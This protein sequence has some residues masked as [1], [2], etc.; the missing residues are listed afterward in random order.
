VKGRRAGGAV[1][2]EHAR[3]E[4]VRRRL[5]QIDRGIEVKLAKGRAWI[6]DEQIPASKVAAAE[7]AV[8]PFKALD[9]AR[10]RQRR[11][12]ERF[13]SGPASRPLSSAALARMLGTTEHAAVAEAM[14]AFA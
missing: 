4:L 13:L 12:K 10:L 11:A 5:P 3:S 1:L 2:A 9:D 7:Q 14:G 8:I 6:A